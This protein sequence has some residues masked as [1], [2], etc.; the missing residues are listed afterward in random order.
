MP[1][2]ASSKR[3]GI[4][5]SLDEDTLGKLNDFCKQNF[6]AER[7]AVIEEALRKFFEGVKK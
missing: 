4:S 1:K 6:N 7:S 5:I 3:I 2:R